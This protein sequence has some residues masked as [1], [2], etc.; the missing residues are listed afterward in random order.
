MDGNDEGH[1]EYLQANIFKPNRHR[2]FHN[3]ND[4]TFHDWI[5]VGPKVYGGGGLSQGQVFFIG[6]LSGVAAAQ[7]SVV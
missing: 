6:A 2:T 1:S 3:G 7:T 4:A 5:F